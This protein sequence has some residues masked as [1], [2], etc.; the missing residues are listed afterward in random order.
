MALLPR[1]AWA[2]AA[3]LAGCSNG[4]S[5]TEGTGS[6]GAGDPLTHLSPTAPGPLSPGNAGG[7]DEDPSILVARDGTL[8]A[9]WYSN[10]AGKHP[11]GR[12]R[13]EIFLTRSTD[14]A[15]WSEPM[16][17]TDSPEWSFYPSLAEGD[18]GSIHVAWMR[19]YLLPDGCEPDP[20]LCAGGPS[21]CTGADKR[22]AYASSPDGLSWSTADELTDGAGDEL[23]H[24]VIAADGSRLVYFASGT[25]GGDAVLRLYAVVHD[26]DDWG[27]PVLLDGVSSDVDHDTFPSVV[28]ASPGQYLM[29]WTRYDLVEGGN[30]FNATT[31]TMLASSSDG[32]AWSAPVVLSD[33]DQ[34]PAID[35]FPYLYPDHARERWSA[36]WM[37]ARVGA[38]EATVV[39]LPTDG[40]FPTD[41][42]TLDLPGYT[43]R[44]A[45]TPTPGIY[46][47]AWVAGDA[48]DQKIEH[49]FFER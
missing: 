29:A 22:I 11:N 13:K 5:D 35:V 12:E 30:L 24:L 3:A 6:T 18:D 27:A 26:G 25:R 33:D 1:G 46:W 37:T 7:Q 10:R 16:Q 49:R 4:P 8:Y 42:G 31:D 45:P 17:L 32:L 9:A 23:P 36:L 19:W 34:T 14:G 28:E 15:T 41:L 2:F 48:P 40:A 43:P 44:V 47:G 21:C 20:D 39:D 38:T